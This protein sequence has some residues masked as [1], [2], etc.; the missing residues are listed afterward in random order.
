M[1]GVKTTH[2]DYDRFS[3]KWKR[4]RDVIAGQD[5]IHAA[6]IAYL[7]KLHDED[8]TEYKARLGRSDFFNGTW[9]T[10]DGLGGMA[11]RKAPTVTVPGGIEPYLGDINL[12]GADM[13]ALASETVEEVLGLGRIGILVDHPA[14]P[15]KVSPI[16]VDAA[17]RMGLRPTLQIYTAES[18]INW[19]FARVNNA[20]VLA[21][22]VLKECEAVADGEFA[23]K[24]ED[25]FR[26]LDLDGNAYR[27]RVFKVDA[28]SK[29]VLLS[30]VYPLKQGR[31]LDFIPFA[32]IGTGGR[33]DVIDE[34]PLIDLVDTNLALYQINADYRHGLH[35]TGLPTPYVCGY[36]SDGT[37][38]KFHIGSTSAWIFADPTTQVGFL[39]F[40]GQG[41]TSLKEAS[42][43][44]KQEMALLGA[45][46]IADETKQVETLGATQIKRSGE[47]SV[48]SKIVQAVG[49]SLEW[50]LTVFADWAGQPGEIVYQINRDFMPTMLDGRSLTALMG[51]VQGGQLSSESFFDLMQRGDIVEAGLS[52]E[53]EQAR[54]EASGPVAPV[55]VAPIKADPNAPP[56]DKA[57]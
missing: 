18:I 51:I 43:E 56:R 36:S 40:T 46:M 29:D 13:D 44:K 41:L 48:L 50:C 32:I 16:T 5:A 12:A 33:G 17:Q 15:D 10:I 7:P 49:Q 14:L 34:P 52:F 19:K 39:E 28:A 2:K 23:E 42:L 37:A 1:A 8:D 38:E 53:E 3:P 24:L 45:R 11:F 35:F 4:C 47:N 25:R 30:E 22:V 54:I 57:V 9:R 55:V 20:W 27:Q 6:T 31:P 26:V 21:M